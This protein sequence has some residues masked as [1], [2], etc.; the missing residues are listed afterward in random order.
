MD[1]LLGFEPKLKLSKSFVLTITLQAILKLVER[2]GVEP[3]TFWLQT[4]C[5]SLPWANAPKLNWND[6]HLVHPWVLIITG[7]RE[8]HLTFHL[9]KLVGVAGFEPALS[10]PQ[11]ERLAWLAYT[12]NKMAGPLGFEPRPKVLE[13]S[14]LA[15]YTTDLNKIENTN[16][17]KEL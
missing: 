8:R 3:T 9:S 6:L 2:V 5:S 15:N 1:G 14:I 17:R 4:R 13:T 7:Q 10:R 11:T 16:I 12:P